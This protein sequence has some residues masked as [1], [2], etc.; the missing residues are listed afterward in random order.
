[1]A[2]ASYIRKTPGDKHDAESMN[3]AVEKMVA[4]ALKC[5]PVVNILETNVEENIF[6]PEFVAQLDHIKLPA[7]KLEVLVK[8]LRK[9]IKEYKNTNKIAAE[10]HE[11]LLRK[12]LEEYHNRR[13]KLIPEE[14]SQAQNEAID[15]II[16]NATQQALDI[17]AGLGENKESFRKLGLTFEEKAFY[18]ILIHLRDKYNFEYGEDKNI[19]G[20]IIND[21]CKVLAKKIKE[22]IDVQSSFTDWLNNTNVRA[23]LNQ[24]IF[25]C[26]V[27]VGYPPQY[28][29]EVFEQV[30]E[31]VENFKKNG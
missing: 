1:M 3:R 6:S 22:L 11:E 4:E 20:L 9:S 17:L 13:A 5:N 30:M 21:K 28:N 8:L 27:Q 29:D 18:D 25:F 15:E 26:L 16:K 31:Q 23:E 2:V 7:T 14:A 10:K 19:G 12:T 24:K